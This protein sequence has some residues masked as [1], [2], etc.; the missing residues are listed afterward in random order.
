MISVTLAYLHWGQ[1]NVKFEIDSDVA[2]GKIEPILTGGK[3]TLLE[4]GATVTG[5]IGRGAI[6]NVGGTGKSSGIKGSGGV[7]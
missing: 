6:R 5:P 1:I 3:T 7:C 4:G 2:S